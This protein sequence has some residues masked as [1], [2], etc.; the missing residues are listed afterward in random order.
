MKSSKSSSVFVT[1]VLIAAF[2]FIAYAA[3]IV[4]S[5]LASDIAH[6]LSNSPWIILVVLVLVILFLLKGL[7]INR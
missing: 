2:L 7:K 5:Q 4:V 6:E 1:L 3:V